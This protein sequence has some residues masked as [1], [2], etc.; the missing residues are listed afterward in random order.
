M[1]TF[2]G[3]EAAT[4][5]ERRDATVPVILTVDDEPA[6]LRAVAGDLRRHYAGRYR[7]VRADSGEAALEV[8]A[9][10]RRRGARLALALSD[11]RMP[12]MAGIDLL[13]E[14][15]RD[16]PDVKAVL[17]TAYADTDVAIAAI[18][19]VRLDY[20]IVK[21]WDPPE[22]FLY[23]PLDELLADWEA[24]AAR[25]AGGLVVVGQRL[26]PEAHALRDFLARNLIPFR[27]VDVSSAPKE[28]SAVLD[29]DVARLPVVVTEDGRRLDRATPA[30]VAEAVGWRSGAREVRAWDLLIIGGGPAGL[31][32]AVYGA[33]EGLRTGVVEREAPGGQAGESSRIENYL[34]FPAG[35]SGADLTRR[36]VTQVRRFGAEFIAPTEAVRLEVCDPYRVVHLTDGERLTATAVILATGVSYRRLNAP[37]MDHLYGRGVYYGAARAEG[38]SCAGEDVV[39]VGGANSAGQ[40]AV[41][42]SSFARRVVV[43]VR[44]ADIAASMSAYLVDQVSA[45]RNVE[46]RTGVEVAG[47][48]GDAGLEAVC[49]RHRDSGEIQRIKARSMFVFIGAEPRTDWLD[50]IV[51]RDARGFIITGP[52][53]GGRVRSPDG[54]ERD[55]YLLET[56]LP[57]TFAVGDARAGSV[58][59]VASAVGEGSIA[60]QF[61]HQYLAL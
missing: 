41:F 52:A 44:G 53:V 56:S 49:V 28:A 43:L 24:G 23:P 47:A 35:L 7:V 33:S 11:Q 10:L 16:E 13:A 42:F 39:I 1:T 48:E 54:S 46:V 22:D 57:G 40:A 50:G 26:S 3:D 25:P 60:V 58:K 9:E 38:P 14:L 8:A 19:R 17:L 2:D 55:R 27:W 36:A 32:A 6:V 34:G 51:E 59:R 15:R 37:G 29:G 45:L 12:G 31:A 61:V 21:P 30:V 4:G 18:N 20:Y 5:R